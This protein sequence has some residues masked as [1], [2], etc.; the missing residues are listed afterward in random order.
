[1]VEALANGLSPAV[2]DSQASHPDELPASQHVPVI[3]GWSHRVRKP[4]GWRI[5]YATFL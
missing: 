1:M 5:F 2:F 4:I 3:V